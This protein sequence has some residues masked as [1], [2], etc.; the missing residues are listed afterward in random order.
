MRAMGSSP[1]ASLSLRRELA[2]RPPTPNEVNSHFV[3]SKD[4]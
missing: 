1:A 2:I 3:I 4:D